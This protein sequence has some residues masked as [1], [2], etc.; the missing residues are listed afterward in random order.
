MTLESYMLAFRRFISRIGIP[1]T[2]Y[3]DNA[4]TFKSAEKEI[5]RSLNI[6]I[7]WKFI[8][9]AAPWYGGWWER[10][11]GLTKTSLRKVLGKALVSAD[12]LRTILTEI[13]CVINDRPITFI[14]SDI[15][16]PQP[17]T[18][19]HLLQGRRISSPEGDHSREAEVDSDIDLN[20]TEANRMLKRK[21]TLMEHFSKR[22]M[23]T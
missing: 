5:S 2:V 7:N 4:P 11:V 12:T 8:Q 18:P 16:D 21:V 14:S 22:K 6:H 10:L 13:E 20:P 1:T 19:L 3:S 17:L 9:R 15:R 23:N